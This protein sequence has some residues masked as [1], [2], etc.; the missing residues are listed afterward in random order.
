MASSDLL[1]V[2]IQGSYKSF[3]IALFE[4]DKLI[5]SSGGL[6]VFLK[7][8]FQASA[9]FLD[10]LKKV[11]GN[12]S[13]SDLDFIAA[14]QGPGAFTSLRV[15]ISSL[16]GL[17]FSDVQGEGINL[18]G[19]DGLDSLAEETR[20]RVD[21]DALIVTML[22]AYNNEVYYGVYENGSSV[23]PKGYKKVD[24]FLQVVHKFGDKKLAFTGNGA[25]MHKELIKD[26]VGESGII[27]LETCSAK[28]VG[29]VGLRQWHEKKNICSELKPLYLKSQTFAVKK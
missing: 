13:L 14:D 29:I 20:E 16:N 12:K 24:D 5:N 10:V 9:R 28:Q 23:V 2:G 4:G 19:V 11:L 22:N 7:G 21:K 18:V 26:V 1:Y 6:D 3:E 25:L 27:S 8:K 15:I 17:A